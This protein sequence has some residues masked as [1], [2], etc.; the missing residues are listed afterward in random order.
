MATLT[1]ADFVKIR[2]WVITTPAVK[3]DLKGWSL[4]K[5]TWRAALQAVEDYMVGG[6][7]VRPATSIRAAI[8]AVTGATTLARAQSLF[9]A[10]VAWKL[11]T[12]VGG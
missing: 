9:A 8:E 6:F 10:W 12:Y 3:A 11:S 2:T 7:T 4:P 1:D 5:A